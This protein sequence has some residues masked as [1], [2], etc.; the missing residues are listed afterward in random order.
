MGSEVQ[1]AP[2]FPHLTDEWEPTNENLWGRVLEVARGDAKRYQQGDRV[3]NS[4]NRGRG[5]YPWPHPKGIAWA[6]KQYNGFG[7]KWRGRQKE[8]TDLE[9]PEGILIPLHMLPRYHAYAQTMGRLEQLYAGTATTKEGDDSHSQLLSMRSAGWARL[10]SRGP[11]GHHYWEITGSGIKAHLQGRWDLL[12]VHVSRHIAGDLSGR[13]FAG[14]FDRNRVHEA[15]APQGARQRLIEAVKVT[16]K[17][18]A[19]LDRLQRLTD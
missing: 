4:P 6:V 16:T 12:R 2:S 17:E 13:E 5:Y 14:W 19:V 8:A 1:A 18:K 3:I 11:R 15:K 7:G 10:N 9:T